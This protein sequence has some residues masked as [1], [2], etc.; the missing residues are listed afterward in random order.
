MKQKP[1]KTQSRLVSIKNV[2]EEKQKKMF[3]YVKEKP[4]KGDV[5]KCM[6]NT[7]DVLYKTTDYEK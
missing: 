6:E 7:R 1:V 3:L 2:Q 5:Y 4:M